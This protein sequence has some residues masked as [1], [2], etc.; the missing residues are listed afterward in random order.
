MV[1]CSTR[2]SDQELSALAEVQR[3]RRRGTTVEI[4]TGDGD[5]LVRSLLALDP[6][7]SGLE[8][9]GAA[10]EDAFLALTEPGSD[11]NKEVA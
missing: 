4:V 3:I 5:L 11:Q 10:L 9:S 2:L 1:R 6:N 8:I 7:L